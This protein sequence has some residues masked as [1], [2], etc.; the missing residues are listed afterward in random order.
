MV[1]TVEFRKHPGLVSVQTYVGPDAGQV[2]ALCV[3]GFDN[4]ISLE[5]FLAK[6]ADVAER[7]FIRPV[8]QY[9]LE[10]FPLYK[11]LGLDLP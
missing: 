5:Q 7:D 2:R 3:F 8:E 1:R 9:R 10:A 11:P 6:R 4:E